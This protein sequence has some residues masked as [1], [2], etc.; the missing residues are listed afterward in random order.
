MKRLIFSIAAAL[1][2]AVAP[3]QAATRGDEPAAAAHLTFAQTVVDLGRI[4]AA[5]DKISF[6]LQYLSDGS[7]PI[8]VTEARTGC[9][10]VTA[11]YKRGKVMPG[12]KGTISVTFDPG[13][14]PE[15]KFFRVIQIFSNAS[16]G[17]ARVTIKAEI[18]K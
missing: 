15:G 9:S 5:A 3:S 16:T 2:M 8:V 17:A 12:D 14:A 4:S 1:S 13:K 18:V 7:A 6:D 11:A 10:C